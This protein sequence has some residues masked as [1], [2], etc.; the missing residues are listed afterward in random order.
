MMTLKKLLVVKNTYSVVSGAIELL[1]GGNVVLFILLFGFSVVFPVCKMVFLFRIWNAA[2]SDIDKVKRGVH[3]VSILG[4]WSM[5][6]VF[7]VAV[8]LMSVKLGALASV[9]IHFGLYVFAA[10]ILLTMLVTAKVEQIAGSYERT[11]GSGPGED[12]IPKPD[13]SN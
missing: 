8:L 3:I 11:H 10:S 7:A 12:A 9:Q 1:N 2:F 5:L 13:G 4:K 6:D